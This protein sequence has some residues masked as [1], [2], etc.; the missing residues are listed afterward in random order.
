MPITSV[1]FQ[2]EKQAKPKKTNKKRKRR[3]KKKRKKGKEKRKKSKELNERV[4]QFIVKKPSNSDYDETMNW[5]NIRIPSTYF[6]LS[7]SMLMARGNAG[8]IFVSKL[9][10]IPL[11]I[12]RFP[13][14]VIF[15]SFLNKLEGLFFWL[16]IFN[17]LDDINCDILLSVPLLM[18]V[19]NTTQ[20][21]VVHFLTNNFFGLIIPEHLL[22]RKLEWAISTEDTVNG[23]PKPVM[24][25]R[26]KFFPVV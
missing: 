17:V 19:E 16:S 25:I 4:S 3:T 13:S 2:V 7:K 10:W 14:Q 26:K 18:F 11:P 23:L 9:R 12:I 21:Y 8:E 6:L 1:F 24:F 5:S 20:K 22:F 15:S